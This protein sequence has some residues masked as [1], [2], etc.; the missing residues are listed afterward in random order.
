[1]V[2][3]IQIEMYKILKAKNYLPLLTVLSVFMAISFYASIYDTANN[4]YFMNYFSNIF[5]VNSQFLF[6]MVITIFFSSLLIHEYKHKTVSVLWGSKYSREA[7]L[8]AKFIAGSVYAI[9][10]LSALTLLYIGIVQMFFADIKE[11][12]FEISDLLFA[13]F[14]VFITTILYLLCFGGM[15]FLISIITKNYGLTILISFALVLSLNFMPFPKVVW[16]YLFFRGANV[17]T[18]LGLSELPTIEIVKQILVTITTL[19]IFLGLNALIFHR[20]QLKK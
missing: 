6:P 4:T 14:M 13:M 2:N 18:V 11:M 7:I 1:M 15:V 17:Y 16:D 19:L 12:P 20:Q 9:I 3:L 10:I 5:A 8:F